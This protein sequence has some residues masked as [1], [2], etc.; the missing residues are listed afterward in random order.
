MYTTRCDSRKKNI[1]ANVLVIS[2]RNVGRMRLNECTKALARFE[3][4]SP[5]IDLVPVC[6]RCTKALEV[7]TGTAPMLPVQK[8]W[9]AAFT[10]IYL[11][12][13]SS[14]RR[15]MVLEFHQH[16]CILASATSAA[17]ISGASPIKESNL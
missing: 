13:F 2:L 8:D 6:Y 1:G 7:Y 12:S 15:L 17:P 16:L 11:D 5:V 14:F 9:C 4:A 10:L 3:L